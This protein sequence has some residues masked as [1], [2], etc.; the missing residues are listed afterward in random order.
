[1]AGV[2]RK[3]FIADV[4]DQETRRGKVRFQTRLTLN[5]EKKLKP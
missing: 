1:M 3:D 2:V 5:A 4:K